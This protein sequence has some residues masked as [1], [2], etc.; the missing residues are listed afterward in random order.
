ME[1]ITF[2]FDFIL[3]VD[4]YL[5]A[6]VRSYGLWVYALLFLVIFVETGVVVMPFLPGD[7]LLFVV[8]AMCG[9]GLMSYPLSVGL[10]LAAAVMGNQSNYAL[11]RYFG[12]RVFKWE[13]SRLFNKAAFN[14]AHDFYE[15]YGGITIVAARFMPFVRTFAPFVAGVAKMSR[16]RFTFF[17]VTGGILWVV[18][19]ITIGYFFGN[20]PFVK[21]HLDKIIWAM[22]LI[23][24]LVIVFGAWKAKRN[25][26]QL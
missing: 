17:D 3:H 11:G 1:I 12:P 14:R 23:P 5:E 2:L 6:F 4:K 10:L 20:I 15:R 13:D 18:G 8:G 21:A 19:I 24:G 9:V 26:V 22:I 7:S 16:A 25:A